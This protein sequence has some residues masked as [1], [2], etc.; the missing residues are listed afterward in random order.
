[1]SCG[2]RWCQSLEG[3]DF[4]VVDVSVSLYMILRGNGP[5]LFDRVGIRYLR[6]PI[7]LMSIRLSC[8]RCPHIFYFTVGTLI[9][10]SCIFHIFRGLA[11]PSSFCCDSIHETK[12]WG[13]VWPSSFVGLILRNL[14][15]RG[16]FINGIWVTIWENYVIL[17][18][19]STNGGSFVSS[20]VWRHQFIIFQM[21]L[22]EDLIL[23]TIPRH[24]HLCLRLKFVQFN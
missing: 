10:R 18:L 17:H 5:P 9:L 1:M 19:L 23:Q 24:Q 16:Y 11:I 13:N 20:F 3:V 21:I 4:V 8:R 22:L 2:R 6:T 7:F 12:L 14:S 15:S